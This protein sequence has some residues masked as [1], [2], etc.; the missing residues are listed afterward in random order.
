MMSKTAADV[1]VAVARM[2]RRA[3]AV[4]VGLGATK[5]N[6]NHT[7][8][9]FFFLNEKRKKKHKIS[10]NNHVIHYTLIDS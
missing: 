8:V 6:H 5:S 7:I 3:A 9:M 2:A 10:K 4:H 1:V